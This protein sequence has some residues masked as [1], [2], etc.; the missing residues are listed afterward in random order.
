MAVE[1]NYTAIYEIIVLRNAVISSCHIILIK[2][3][4]F[5]FFVGFIEFKK[6]A[7]PSKVHFP[8]KSSKSRD[9][10]KSAYFNNY[11]ND[12]YDDYLNNYYNCDF[13]YDVLRFL[14]K[15]YSYLYSYI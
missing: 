8:V 7:F 13:A 1:D 6:S 12:Y 2:S 10:Y 3:R 9:Y 4:H 14:I 15:F 5:E 11:Y